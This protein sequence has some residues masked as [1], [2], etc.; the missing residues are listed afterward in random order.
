M[1]V[2]RVRIVKSYW[3]GLS[4]TAV[5]TCQSRGPILLVWFWSWFGLDLRKEKYTLCVRSSTT[6]CPYVLPRSLLPFCILTVSKTAFST[7]LL[8]SFLPLFRARPWSSSPPPSR[9]RT[10]GSSSTASTSR[11]RATSSRTRNR[12]EINTEQDK[13]CFPLHP[14]LWTGLKI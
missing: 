7:L 9:T 1:N 6:V 8:I 4:N 14:R 13:R 5:E 3:Q 2:A 11:R 10:S 12:E